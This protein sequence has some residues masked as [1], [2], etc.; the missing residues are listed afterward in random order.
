MSRPVTI[1]EVYRR[2]RCLNQSELARKTGIHQAR[3][4]LI[5]R[6]EVVPNEREINA[7]ADYFGISVEQ[8]KCLVAKAKKATV[9]RS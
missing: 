1:F 4:S 3:I 9:R 8:V 6:Q 2:Q 5:E 7:L